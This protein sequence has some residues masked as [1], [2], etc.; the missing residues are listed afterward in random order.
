MLGKRVSF[1]PRLSRR[2]PVEAV[3]SLVMTFNEGIFLERM[4]GIETGHAGLLAMID[5]WVAS[6]ERERKR[7]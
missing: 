6:M 5:R 3:V 1:A 7:S 2:F 4:S